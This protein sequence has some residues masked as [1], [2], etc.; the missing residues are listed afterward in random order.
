MSNERTGRVWGAHCINHSWHHPSTSIA[1]IVWK[2][3]GQHVFLNVIPTTSLLEHDKEFG[4]IGTWETNRS[5][6]KT[7]WKYRSFLREIYTK[8][9]RFSKGTTERSHN[10][11][12]VGTLNTRILTKYAQDSPRTLNSSGWCHCRLSSLILYCPCWM[13]LTPFS[14]GSGKGFFFGGGGG[15]IFF[16]SLS[17][18][19]PTL[20]FQVLQFPCFFHVH[21]RC[22]REGQVTHEAEGPWPWHFKH[23]HWWKGR[24][25]S[26][27][28]SRYT[29]GTDGVCEC[30]M[31]VKSTWI[32]TWHQTNH[33][34]WS[35][36]LFSK[37]TSWR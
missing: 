8:S 13:L 35:L 3:V 33:I 21:G 9:P 26:R 20:Y 25:R 29:W 12:P 4:V 17:F 34:S 6:F 22:T 24:S 1:I 14:S 11:K 15:L 16:V 30:K 10:M 37:S 5:K 32:F 31:D 7:S 19:L 23:S 2:V 27:F 36:G 18:L 28:A